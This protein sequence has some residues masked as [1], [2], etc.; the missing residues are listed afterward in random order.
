MGFIYK[1]VVDFFQ[2]TKGIK[3]PGLEFQTV[4][5]FAHIHQNKGLFVPVYK[6]SGEL[7][8]AIENGALAAVWKEG[9]SIPS[10][11]PN[12]FPI[13]YSNDLLKGIEY[14]ITNLQEK[15]DWIFFEARKLNDIWMKKDVSEMIVALQQEID[16][17]GKEGTK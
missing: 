11:T 13:L 6:D 7:M 3:D 8:K 9:E 14:M 15:A 12:D 16:V 10:Y 1:E 2:H 5:A 17:R 4:S